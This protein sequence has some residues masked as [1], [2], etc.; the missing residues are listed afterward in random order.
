GTDERIF[1][2]LYPKTR[3]S[4]PISNS[5]ASK[6]CTSFDTSGHINSTSRSEQIGQE[7]DRFSLTGV[8]VDFH[9]LRER[10]RKN[11]ALPKDGVVEVS[12][13]T[14]FNGDRIL[15]EIVVND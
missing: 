10:F 11:F 15:R 14:L 3:D 2:S 6:T 4:K 1:R 13:D 9:A 5:G 8:H 7:I 12:E